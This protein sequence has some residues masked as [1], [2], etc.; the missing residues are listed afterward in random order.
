[1][2]VPENLTEVG[3]GTILAPATVQVVQVPS[4]EPSTPKR[5]IEPLNKVI[6]S[7]CAEASLIR[8]VC[9]LTSAW[10]KLS[11]LAF[12]LVDSDDDCEEATTLLE[13]LLQA[14]AVVGNRPIDHP[15]SLE[16]E[17]QE[18]IEQ[19]SQRMKKF[20]PRAA[21]GG[22]VRTHTRETK[23]LCL[24]SSIIAWHSNIL[25]LLHNAPPSLIPTAN[26]IYNRANESGGCLLGAQRNTFSNQSDA[27]TFYIMYLRAPLS[28]KFQELNIPKQYCVWFCPTSVFCAHPFHAMGGPERYFL[29]VYIP[30]Y[31]TIAR[32][33]ELEAERE[34]ER[35]EG[36]DVDDNTETDELWHAETER[37]IME[38]SSILRYYPEWYHD[39]QYKGN[40]G[41]E[42][43]WLNERD[44]REGKTGQNGR[45]LKE[46]VAPVVN[47]LA[48][49]LH[50]FSN[51][52]GHWII[53]TP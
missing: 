38:G 49:S 26:D 12:F 13:N 47:L 11:F 37:F 23:E 15:W 16:G 44:E 1:M 24:K 41:D 43:D 52:Q 33:C 40:C 27:S 45:R 9:M 18:I 14:R 42:G 4:A 7:R 8:A 30:S 39:W 25:T 6:K 46:N 35:E 21:K 51:F 31:C 22:H 50:T 3:S 48:G 36:F 28:N 53:R 19:N 2:S 17:C 32:P 34:K 5:E 10:P 20:E 29:N